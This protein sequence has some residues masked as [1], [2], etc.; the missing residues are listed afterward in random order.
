MEF[1]AAARNLTTVSPSMGP[2]RDS[3][4]FHLP[5]PQFDAFYHRRTA[6]LVTAAVNV[7]LSPFAVAANFLILFIISK[8]SSLHTPSNLLIACLAISDILVGLV[9]QPSYV[10]YRLL[11]NQYGFVPCSVRMLYS[12]GFYVCYGVSFMTLC[13][14]GCERLLALL[15]HLRYLEIVCRDRVVKAVLLIWFVN[16]SL[17]FLQWAHNDTF[18]AIHLGLWVLSLLIA[19]ATQCRIIP[20]IRHHQGQIRNLNPTHCSSR[21]MQIKLAMNI[22]SIL[23]I[24]FALNLPVLVIAIYHQVVTKQISSYNLYSWAETVAFTN[25]SLN[26]LVC[27]WRV[28]SIRNGITGLRIW[29]RLQLGRRR[30]RNVKTPGAIPKDQDLDLVRFRQITA[31]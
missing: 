17:T 5:D 6:N 18:R 22:A 10:A 15:C 19:V 31:P 3:A 24:Y 2:T 28:R 9:V 20:I 26:P 21:Q 4:C 7:I 13:T 25:S 14:I 16:I 8:L 30:L 29:R 11:E 12:T 23:T 1:I 27:L